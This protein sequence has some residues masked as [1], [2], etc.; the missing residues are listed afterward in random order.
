MMHMNICITGALGH[1]GSA[2]IRN[3]QVSNLGEVHLVDNLSSQRYVSLM[4]LPRQREFVFHEMDIRA[5][6]I[7]GVIEKCDVLIHLAAISDTKTSIEQPR[8]VKEINIDALKQLVQY[9]H[10][11]KTALLFPSTTSVY[12]GKDVVLDEQCAAK[13]IKPQTP[14]AQS[15]LI[16]ENYIRKFSQMNRLKFVIFR[17]GTI[18]GHS[19]GMRFNTAVNKFI[20]QALSGQEISV[21]ET[22][23]YQR[24]PYCQLRDC[25]K[26]INYFVENKLFDGEVY[27]VATGNYQVAEIISEIRSF[28]SGLKVRPVKS[29]IMNKLSY[30]VSCKRAQAK[31]VKL[32]GDLSSAIR[33]TIQQLQGLNYQ[34]KIKKI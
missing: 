9:C 22:A 2:F 33:E 34:V 25:I 20:Y 1:I 7:E 30:G 11:H 28:I 21:W 16:G 8:L 15:K 32:E 23:L 14:Y 6:E 31:G 24:R 19:V 13:Y 26:T 10:K 4:Q 18:F 29:K 3:L 17:I 5:P 12:S 27:N